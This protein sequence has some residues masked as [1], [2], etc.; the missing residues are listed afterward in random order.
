M[1]SEHANSIVFI[2][3]DDPTNMN[4]L[5]DALSQA[6][7]SV[8]VAKSGEE[9]LKQVEAVNPDI[10]L[11][12]VVMPGI[13]GF[14]TCRR[15]KDNAATREIP[16]MFMTALAETVD[17]ITGFEVGGVDYITKPFQH[18]KLLARVNA[19]LTIRQQQRQLRELNVDLAAERA[20]LADQVRERTAELS[21]ANAELSQ[22]LR[23]KNE[24]LSTMSH[25]LR[26]PLNVILGMSE[27]LQEELHGSLNARQRKFIGSI[28]TNGQR[29]FTLL[30]D[31]LEF[32]HIV[33][34]KITLEIVPTR[35]DAVCQ[36]ALQRINQQARKKH[37]KLSCML[38]NAVTLIQA[39]EDYV[40]HIFD[41]LLDNAVKFTPEGGEIGLE[42]T[43]DSAQ[44]VVRFTVW[45]TGI[46]IA[47]DDLGRL[48]Q[49][50]VQL[51]GSLSR[52]FEGA[53]IGLTLT[54]HLVDLHGGSI[55]VESEVGEGSRFTVS[56]PWQESH[57]S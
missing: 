32:A 6:G 37:L 40:Q 8:S 30:T 28:E 33:A 1:R 15:L 5:T 26:T 55:A 24:F 35:L 45:D 13:D 12:D 51:D 44:H 14:E 17:E 25:E 54:R 52:A 41:K 20:S 21:A 29:L 46:G 23:L 18:E 22:A 39:D 3:D 11:L 47:Q 57:E 19:Q 49:S 48:F 9:A 2:V 42:V 34:G 16:V 7:L 43:G 10:I 27:I 36:A 4:V 56:L 31:I 38:D 53:G 50:F